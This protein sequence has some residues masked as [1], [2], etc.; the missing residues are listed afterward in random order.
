MKVTLQLTGN[1]QSR[2]TT[3][4]VESLKEVELK[5]NTLPREGETILLP[6]FP[7]SIVVKSVTHAYKYNRF[8][9]VDGKSKV[10]TQEEIILMLG[11][12]NDL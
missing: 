9:Q 10:M 1:L 7:L 8:Y 2:L 6:G 11:S 12:R 3:E 4:Q 5:Q